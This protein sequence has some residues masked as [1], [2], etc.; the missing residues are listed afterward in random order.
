MSLLDA[1]GA[2]LCWACRWLN[3]CSKCTGDCSCPNHLQSADGVS[4]VR[5]TEPS[6]AVTDQE[7]NKMGKRSS[8]AVAEPEAVEAEATVDPTEFA[9][10]VPSVEGGSPEN[11]AEGDYST[12]DDAPEPDATVA[13]E[14]TENADQPETPAA[15]A[16]AKE[17]KQR[18]DLEAQVKEVTDAFVT[19]TLV[20]GEGEFLTPHRIGKEI[21]GKYG[22]KPST[23]AVQSAVK[24]WSEC[25]FAQVNEKPYAFVDYTEAGRTQGLSALKAAAAE[26]RKAAKA[27]EKA[28]AAP[29]ADAGGE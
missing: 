9:D 24:R 14:A 15:D 27:A 16:P 17:R 4:N 2:L 18:G 13:A 25:G 26:Q 23:G 8:T 1:P 5:S 19:G 20:L 22:D 21:A 3:G 6:R 29:A 7:V 10:A 12:P 11:A 28:A